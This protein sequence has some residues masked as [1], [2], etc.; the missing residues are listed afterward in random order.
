MRVIATSKDLTGLEGA[1]RRLV[2]REIIETTAGGYRFKVELVRRW[3][4]RQ[5]TSL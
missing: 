2:R 3:V 1:L 4:E 5:V